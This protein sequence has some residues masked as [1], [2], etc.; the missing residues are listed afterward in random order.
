M[1]RYILYPAV[2]QT[3]L[4]QDGNTIPPQGGGPYLINSYYEAKILQGLL[5]RVDPLASGELPMLPPGPGTTIPGVITASLQ[6]RGSSRADE[7]VVTIGGA[8]QSD[9]AD[10]KFR[11]IG[12]TGTPDN[13]YRVFSGSGGNWQRSMDRNHIDLHRY[14]GAP[15]N[16]DADLRPVLESACDFA[17]SLTDTP[18]RPARFFLREGITLSNLNPSPKTFIYRLSAPWAP[19]PGN[20]RPIILTGEHHPTMNASRAPYGHAEWTGDRPFA[21]TI[22]RADEDEHC[23]EMHNDGVSDPSVTAYRRVVLDGIALISTGDGICIAHT[24]VP[25]DFGCGNVWLRDVTLAGGKV[26][27]QVNS[28]ETAEHYNVQIVGCD[29]ALRTGDGVTYGGMSAQDF[30]GLSIYACNTGI[31]FLSALGCNFFGGTWQGVGSVIKT[32]ANCSVEHILLVGQ[33]IEVYNKL[34][35]THS[36]TVKSSIRMRDC[37][38]AGTL[39]SDAP[40]G[41]VN[42]YG[43][44][45]VFD[46]M[47]ITGAVMNFPG[48]WT[49]SVHQPADIQFISALYGGLGTTP[50]GTRISLDSIPSLERQHNASMGAGTLTADLVAHGYALTRAIAGNITINPPTNYPVSSRRLSIS[51]YQDAP[52]GF[53]V[54]HHASIRG[55]GR[56]S[57]T[58]NVTGTRCN[59]QYERQIDGNWCLMDVAAWT[60]D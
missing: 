36:Q 26:G 28:S 40:L 11:W 31:E 32:N 59:L 14:F 35:D 18:T 51:L 33:H 19:P 22:I 60:A 24:A 30:F 15:Q 53:T 2:G 21:G 56:Y 27:Y 10:D 42:I 57:N 25:G 47:D 1:A 41:P 5:L 8:A 37:R 52:G 45:W 4:D 43:T 16:K 46:S 48:F 49:G 7:L 58:G 3:V 39:G 38:L 29:I 12:S 34:L 54:S 44:G 20:H 17:I 9:G 50:V 6:D 55:A 23:I 13:V